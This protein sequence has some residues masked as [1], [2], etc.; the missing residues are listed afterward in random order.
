MHITLI[1]LVMNLLLIG[2]LLFIGFVAGN[3]L[4]QY[5]EEKV[6]KAAKRH[7]QNKGGDRK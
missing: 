7:D 6:E 4:V 5:I 3:A 2:W 1:D